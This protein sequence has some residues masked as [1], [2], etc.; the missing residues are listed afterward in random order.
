MNSL[1]DSKRIKIGIGFFGLP[2]NTDRT[3]TSIQEYILQPAAQFGTIV[4]Y[5]HF[6]HQTRVVNKRSFEND[7]LDPRQYQVFAGFQ[8]ELE[9]PEGVPEKWGFV[10]ISAR[11]DAW[12]D[13]FHSL[14]NLLLQLH[15]LRQLTL[16]LETFE[17]DIVIF[18]RPDLL[19]HHSFSPA[20][21]V[22]S[23]VNTEKMVYLPFWQ[24]AGGYNDR[25]A[26][27]G[28]HAFNAYGKRIELMQSY[29]TSYSRRPLH[30]ERLLRFALDKSLLAVRRLDVQATRVRVSGDEVREDFS[31]VQ[32]NRLVRWKFREIR[33][34]VGRLM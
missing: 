9:S 32:L 12:K 28:K 6:Y 21:K 15:S 27:C 3:F 20:L 33:K 19:Y 31:G 29:L 24:W 13:E 2:R 5:Y 14:R 7:E 10:E 30:A 4:P 1:V 18:A 11:G 16:R 22:M 25:F 8:G 17:P 26:I 23:A 34:A